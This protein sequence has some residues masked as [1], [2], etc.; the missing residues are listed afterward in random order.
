MTTA[1]ATVERVPTKSWN[2]TERKAISDTIVY[3]LTR[4]G[5]SGRL[6]SMLGTKYLSV[7]EINHNISIQFNFKMCAKCNMVEIE[8]DNGTDTYN[9]KF[10]KHSNARYYAKTGKITD[11]KHVTVASFE[12]VYCD[13]LEFLFSDFTGLVTHL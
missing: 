2:E 7:F 6:V 5:K 13:Q 11:T 4:G 9:V 12:D 10:I 8:L 3:Q 1:T